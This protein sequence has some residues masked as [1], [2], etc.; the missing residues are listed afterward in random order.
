[1]SGGII[2]N[3]AEKPLNHNNSN[4]EVYVINAT[5]KTRVFPS[6]ETSDV[7]GFVLINKLVVN[8]ENRVD[9]L[10]DEVVEKLV[11]QQKY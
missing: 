8:E 2:G 5:N 11:D 6:D 1:M 7:L 4:N 9:G 10:Q 3:K